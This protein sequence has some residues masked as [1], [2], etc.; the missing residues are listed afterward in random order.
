[1]N[2][3]IAGDFCQ[4]YRVDELI[5]EKRYAE[6]FDDVRPII[7]LA[8][9]SIVNFE[10]PIVARPTDAKPIAKCGPNLRGTIE[11]VEA[12]KYA[13]FDCC[14][15]ANNHTLDQ[16]QKCCLDTKTELEKAGID[17]VGVG[18]N[19]QEAANTLYKEIEGQTLAIINCCEHE[20]TIA[21][22]TTPGANA[23]NPIQQFYKI[24]EAKEQADY[25]LVITHGGHEHYNLPSPRMKE[26]YR[27]FIE[28]GADAVVNHH[29]HCYSGFET[30][31]SKP[32]FYGLGNF[33]FDNPSHRNSI[34]NSGFMVELEFKSQGVSHK[35]H[36]YVQCTE[37]VSVTPMSAAEKAKFEDNIRELSNTI[38]DD[39]KLKQE[40]DKYYSSW[41]KA[42]MEIL[43]PYSN[44]ITRK[45]LN[46]GLLP[47]HIKG[48]KV[49]QI[50]NHV[51]CEAHRDKLI[52][53]LTKRNR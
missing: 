5:K 7:Q 23:L 3:L 13:G 24:K 36:P 35:L 17:T 41:C 21:T 37:N 48:K 28:A 38:T 46:L 47:R 44:K 27:F 10:F 11:S 25:V 18:G 19:A 31:N 53:A 39:C 8:D 50:L 22:D 16:G 15:L 2:I 51:D 43:E 49:A 4:R 30:Y 26:L 9:Y 1:M 6:L 40:T 29:Q 33:C 52:F 20:F 45:L 34:W 42:E 14:T 32:I 12:V